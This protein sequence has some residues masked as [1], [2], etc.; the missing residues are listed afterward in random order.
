MHKHKMKKTTLYLILLIFVSDLV[1][2]IL[3]I[4]TGNIL[5]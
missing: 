1:M 3:L 2:L 4:I 5:V